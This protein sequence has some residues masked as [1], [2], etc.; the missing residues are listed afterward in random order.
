M[1]KFSKKWMGT[2]IDGELPKDD[3]FILQEVSKK[4]FEVEAFEVVKDADGKE[5]TLFEIKVLPNRIADVFSVRGMAREFAAVLGLK[6]GGHI[7]VPNLD[8]FKLN[9]DFV[10]TTPSS[11][12]TLS[13]KEESQVPIYIFTGVK[14]NNFDNTK[15]TPEWI[16]DIIS[17]SGG[18][19]I[20]CLVDITNL[21]LFSFGQPAHVFDADK[22]TGKI[23]TRFARAGS[24]TIKNLWT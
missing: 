22:L 18:R 23:I 10:K 20:N 4:G 17:K 7:P 15:E 1:K 19:S 21:I 12:D 9:N 3:N 24:L 13:E 6:W 16:K 2:F 8:D 5:D 14:V 11:L